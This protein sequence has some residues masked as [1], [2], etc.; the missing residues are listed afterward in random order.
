MSE[1]ISVYIFAHNRL[2]FV[3]CVSIDPFELEF[4]RIFSRH[5]LSLVPRLSEGEKREPGTD[6]LRMRLFQTFVVYDVTT[7]TRASAYAIRNLLSA[8]ARNARRT[9]VHVHAS[10]CCGCRPHGWKPPAYTAIIS[11][12]DQLLW[13]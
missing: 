1:L 6:R 12:F 2:N 8:Y 5:F 10:V 13:L 3:P 7:L 9:P 11:V 4:Y